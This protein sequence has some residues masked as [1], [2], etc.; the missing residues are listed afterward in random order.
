MM[1]HGS[2]NGNSRSSATGNEATPYRRRR[3]RTACLRTGAGSSHC[4]QTACCV[5][6]LIEEEEDDL[7]ASSSIYLSL[8]YLTAVYSVLHLH[9]ACLYFVFRVLVIIRTATIIAI[10]NTSKVVAAFLSFSSPPTASKEQPCSFPTPAIRPAW[11]LLPQ[12][13]ESSNSHQ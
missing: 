13:T 8:T 9:V 11:R 2:F 6:L 12:P 3:R 5:G 10:W 7:I 1:M 4:P